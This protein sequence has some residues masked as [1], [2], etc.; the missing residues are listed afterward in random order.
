M[1]RLTKAS[2]LAGLVVAGQLYAQPVS[3]P[4]KQER[5]E[6]PTKAATELTATEMLSSGNKLKEQVRSDTQQVQ[7]LQIV[8]R[9]EKD[10]LKLSCVNDKYVKLKAEA[11]LV[12]TA[13]GELTGSQGQ[14][15]PAFA[16]ATQHTQNVAK[17]REEAQACVGEPELGEKSSNDYSHP[18]IPDDP[19][20]GGMPFEEGAVEPPGYASPY[21]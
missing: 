1:K 17:L 7:H 10:V 6:A 12:D 20:S 2:I 4:A 13:L 15:R 16:A 18:D 21:T 14:S 3:V 11:N 9:R 8:A 5:V 19:T